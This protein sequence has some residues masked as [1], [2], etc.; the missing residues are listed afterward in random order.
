MWYKPMTARKIALWAIPVSAI[1][2]LLGAIIT[3]LDKI[4]YNHQE[5]IVMLPLAF[6]FW[7]AIFYL[8]LLLIAMSFF[9]ITRLFAPPRD[10]GG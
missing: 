9:G 6:L 3:L 8:A 7:W 2:P 4:R 10:N 5:D 1:L